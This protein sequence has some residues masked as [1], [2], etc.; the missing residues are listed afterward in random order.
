MK[1]PFKTWKNR[2]KGNW[3][4]T[5]SDP[6]IATK[7]N[8]N[9]IKYLIILICIII[10]VNIFLAIKKMAS[11]GFSAMSLLVQGAMVLVGFFIVQKMYFSV[12][13]PLKKTMDHYT[14]NPITQTTKYVNVGEEVDEILKK[15]EVQEKKDGKTK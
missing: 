13:N 2:I 4:T 9:A 7:M 11:H 6:Y 15:F 10:S 5:R 8:Y 3:N 1:N 14:A 12:M